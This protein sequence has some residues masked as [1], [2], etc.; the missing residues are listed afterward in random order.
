M[1]HRAYGDRAV[2]WI[3]IEVDNV[4]FVSH[5]LMRTL[6]TAANAT[7]KVGVAQLVDLLVY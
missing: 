2:G 3:L 1:Y 5:Q 4:I 6:H 7:R